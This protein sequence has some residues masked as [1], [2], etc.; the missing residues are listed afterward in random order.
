MINWLTVWVAVAIVMAIQLA[1][2]A[3][4]WYFTERRGKHGKS[5]DK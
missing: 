1:G 3:A 2:I 5:K 4:E